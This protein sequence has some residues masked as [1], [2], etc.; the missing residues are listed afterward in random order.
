[1][2]K[3]HIYR[4]GATFVIVSVASV[5]DQMGAAAFSPGFG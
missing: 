5:Y 3:Y 2:N 1:M 4:V